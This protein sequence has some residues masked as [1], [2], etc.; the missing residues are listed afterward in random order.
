MLPSGLGCEVSEATELTARAKTQVLERGGDHLTFETIER[1]RDAFESLEAIQCSLSAL[2]L[3]RNHSADH[4]PQ[5]LRRGAI[6]PRTASRVSGS[7]LANE[8][9]KLL[10][11]AEKRTRDVQLLSANENLQTRRRE[12]K[13]REKSKG[14]IENNI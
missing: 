12:G 13:R 1:V 4:A 2:R 8:T 5:N 14:K 6:M 3:V 10:L 9:G 11:V 7:N